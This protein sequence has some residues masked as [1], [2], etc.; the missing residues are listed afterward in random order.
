MRFFKG[1]SLM[2]TAKTPSQI[3]SHLTSLQ[4]KKK[5]KIVQYFIIYIGLFLHNSHYYVVLN[6]PVGSIYF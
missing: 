5:R 3:K 1:Y 6:H 4:E 2:S